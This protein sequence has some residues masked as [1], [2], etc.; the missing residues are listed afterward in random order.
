MDELTVFGPECFE[1]KP[2]R[3]E[4]FKWLQCGE[5]LP[6]RGVF[7]DAWDEAVSLLYAV[8]RA[9]A[10]L[11]RNADG[12]VSVFL[13]LGPDAEAG[14]TRLFRQ[15][16]YVAASLLNTLCDEMLFQM[17]RQAGTLL[18][19]A[20][21]PEG[22]HIAGLMEPMVDLDPQELTR[23]VQPLFR[24]FPYVRISRRGTLFP[25]KSMMYSIALAREGCG[26][27]SLHDCSRCRQTNCLYR[28]I[29]RDE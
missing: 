24:A 20:L 8:I 7:A 25:T 14:V 9:N 2:D 5:G 15:Q 12:A 1:L 23:R 11:I 21:A 19:K 27:H 18:E 13:T 28:S 17:D 26:H 16:R 3:E 6:C 29:R 22:L 4:V 10:V